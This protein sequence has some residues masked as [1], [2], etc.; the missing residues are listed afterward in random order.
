MAK[1]QVG[2][3]RVYLAYAFTSLLIIKERQ[4]RSLRRAGTWKQEL[5]GKP[6]KDAAHY[7]VPP[8]LL[9]L[10]SY[11]TQGHQPRDEATHNGPG[12]PSSITKVFK[13]LTGLPIAGYFGGIFF[14]SVCFVLFLR[15]GCSV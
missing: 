6:R 1:I 14:F 4:D 10:L 7:L 15:Q 9:S 12:L 13:C 2:E 11:R 8:C 5:I 3:E